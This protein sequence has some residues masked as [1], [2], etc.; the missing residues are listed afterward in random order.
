MLSD[1]Q[2]QAY[3]K[4]NHKC[5]YCGCDD[6]SGGSYD[7]DGDKV[8]QDVRCLHPACGRTWTDEYT[9]TGLTESQ[10]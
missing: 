2:K 5:P 3:L 9:L 6:I 8:Y 10:D 4:A 7:Y 1:E